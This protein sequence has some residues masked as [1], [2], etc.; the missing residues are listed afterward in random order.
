LALTVIL[1]KKDK[2]K[3]PTEDR[4]ATETAYQHFTKPPKEFDEQQQQ[5]EEIE[6]RFRRRAIT[7][8]TDQRQTLEGELF[9]M[10]EDWRDS[11][12]GLSAKLKEWNDLYEGV[13]S[14]SNWPWEGASEVH[15]PMPKIKSREIRSTINRTALR[16]VPFLMATYAGPEEDRK[17]YKDMVKKIENFIEDKMKNG[18]NIHLTLKESIGPVIRDGTTPV[19]IIWETEL[20]RV[21]D[22]KLY[23]D[24]QE[25]I[26][27]YPDADSAGISETEFNRLYQQLVDEG[28]CEIA[29][30]YDVPIYDGPKAYIVPLIDFVHWPVYQTEIESMLLHGKRVWYTDYQLEDMYRMG[31]FSDRPVLDLVLGKKGDVRDDAYTSQRDAIEGIDRGTSTSNEFECFELVYKCALDGDKVKTKYLIYWAHKARKVLRIEKYPIRQGKS[32]YFPLRLIK[33][34]NRFLGASLI[35][36]IADL[37]GEI[38]TIHRQ[39]INTRTITHVPSFKAM[40]GAK[41]RF[42]PGRKDLQ[43]R[44]GVVFWLEDTKQVE[45]FDIRPVDLSG[46]IDEENLLYQLVDMVTGSSSGLSGQSNPLDPRAPARKQNEMLRQSTNRIDDYVEVLLFPFAQIG[47]FMLDLYYQYGTKELTYNVKGKDGSLIQ[48]VIDRAMFFDPNVKFRVNGTSVFMNPEQEYNRALE[49]DQILAQNPLTMQNPRVRKESLVRVLD[50]A[51]TPMVENMVPTD[52]ELGIATQDSG[53]TDSEGNPIRRI[54]TAEEGDQAANDKLMQD[55]LASRERESAMKT[56]TDAALR[57]VEAGAGMGGKS[58][59]ASGY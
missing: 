55:K 25:F 16:P 45:Q 59:A 23:T 6:A 51:R 44:P 4:L 34:D 33:R 41:G 30:E 1:P 58:N 57:L 43:F 7:L 47:Q 10:V 56:K 27:D 35:D 29:Y 17:G 49:V 53:A 50:A 22:Y 46:S 39:R 26:D 21:C 36:D 32:T 8:T 40:E 9:R 48:Q 14:I 15:I 54:P 31:K 24:P 38:D 18:T 37:S 19:Q 12:S 3:K 28:Q 13:T 20:E 52:E 2:K 42:D 11:R 5:V